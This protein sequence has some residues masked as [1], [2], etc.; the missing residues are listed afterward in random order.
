MFDFDDIDIDL[1]NLLPRGNGRIFSA[2]FYGVWAIVSTVFIV[3]GF[4]QASTLL[5]AI[6]IGAGVLFLLALLF[7]MAVNMMTGGKPTFVWHFAQNGVAAA[8]GMLAVLLFMFGH[9]VES[10]LR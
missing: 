2:F 4:F 6:H 9:V 5:M 1:G 7:F 8:L 3:S 10:F